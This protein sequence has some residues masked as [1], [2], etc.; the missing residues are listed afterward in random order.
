MLKLAQNKRE[1]KK[2]LNI[3]GVLISGKKAIS[4]RTPIELFDVLTIVPA[5]KHYRLTFSEYGKY[6]FSEIDKSKITTKIE[7]IIGKKVVNGARTQLNFHDGRNTFYDKSASVNDSVVFDIKENKVKKVLEVK[8]GAKVLVIGGKHIGA[9]GE[10]LKLIPEYKM[11]QIKSK[12][13]S[14]NVLVDQL[15]VLE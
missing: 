2:A 7:K 10:I 9:R 12:D 1:V 11:V 15:I 6:T 4:E 14:F 13:I 3:G 8:S 5:D